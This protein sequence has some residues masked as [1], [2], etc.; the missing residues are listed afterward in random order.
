VTILKWVGIVG[1]AGVAIALLVLAYLVASTDQRLG[2]QLAAI[3]AA[4]EPLSWGD[5]VAKAVPPEK[6]AAVFLRRAESDLEAI[7]KELSPIWDR[8]DYYDRPLSAEEQKAVKAAFDAYPKVMPLLEQAAACQE[9]DR[10]IDYAT[11]ASDLEGT[12]F[13]PTGKHRTVAR[14]LTLRVY[15]LLSKSQYDEALRDSILLL[16][17]ARHFEREPMT[18]GYLVGVACKGMGLDAAN[19][20]LQAGPVSKELRKELDAELARHDNLDGYRWAM[21]TE[22]VYGLTQ[23]AAIPARNV[24]PIRAQWNYDE[25]KYLELMDMNLKCVSLPYTEVRASRQKIYAGLHSRFCVLA[26]LVFPAIQSTYDATM[27][28]KASARCLRVIN[29]LQARVPPGSDAVPKLSELGLPAEATTDPFTDKPL[30]VKKLP[31]GWLVYS[32]GED[33]EDSGGAVDSSSGKPKD[34]GLGPPSAKPK[35]PTK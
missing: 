27:R 8:R 13:D 32:V 10:E 2:A 28:T 23:Y 24:W 4:G 26:S 21:R 22:R 34:Y 7:F 1:A 3:R 17:L 30:V 12:L 19:N 14:V 5:L 25:S 11:V 6:N 18:L 9:F 33:L 20:V 31:D 16:R 35:K 15:Y 29:A